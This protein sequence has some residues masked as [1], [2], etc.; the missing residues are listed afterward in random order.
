MRK[1]KCLAEAKDRLD[2]AQR[3]TSVHE[4]EMF[5]TYSWFWLMA[6]AGFPV[7]DAD[8]RRIYE[9]DLHWKRST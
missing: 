4:P 9:G 5:E 1:D 8:G 2:C 7:V 6:W 3:S